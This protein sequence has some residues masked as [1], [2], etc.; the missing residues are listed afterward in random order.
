[1]AF[2]FIF[3]APFSLLTHAYTVNGYDVTTKYNQL[4]DSTL[5]TEFQTTIITATTDSNFYI[6]TIVRFPSTIAKD[7]VIDLTI[8]L[9]HST[10]E[11]IPYVARMYNANNSYIGGFE[12]EVVHEQILVEELEVP[13]DLSYID[14]RFTINNPTWQENIVEEPV[15]NSYVGTWKL[16]DSLGYATTATTAS[17]SGQFY[18]CKSGSLYSADLANIILATSGN[19]VKFASAASTYPYYSTTW[20]S[21]GSAS[22]SY[23]LT[24]SGSSSMSSISSSIVSNA[25]FFVLTAEPSSEVLKAWLDTNAVKQSDDVSLTSTVEYTYNFT[26]TNVDYQIV[27]GDKL[28]GGILGWIKNIWNGITNLPKNIANA[29]KGFFEDV[30]NAVKDLGQFLLDGIVGLFVP[31]EEVMTD[32]KERFENLLADR[33]GAVYDSTQIIDDFANAFNSQSQSA[34]IDGVGANGAISFPAITVNLVEVPFTF[35]GWEVDLIPDKFQGIIDTLKIITNI[36]CTFVFV[37][38]M[39]KRL[40]GVLK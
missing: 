22:S 9:D 1:M 24:S 3:S 19:P 34:M 25:R 10:T 30:V 15:V 29:I 26:V 2:C 12:G 31:T 18:Y 6:Q 8:D 20:T 7:T 23:Q 14:F 21:G 36:A 37:N 16:N 35:G 5:Y 38:G 4:N 13:G 11:S 17:V 33:F 39:R 28:L 32:I 40:D 27:E